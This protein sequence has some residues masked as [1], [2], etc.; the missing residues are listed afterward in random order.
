MLVVV[1]KPSS[2]VYSNL[3]GWRKVVL[4]LCPLIWFDQSGRDNYHS[5]SIIIVLWV[6]QFWKYHPYE[7]I[8]CS[9]IPVF[10]GLFNVPW[11]VLYRIVLLTEVDDHHIKVG[12]FIYSIQA[13]W[14]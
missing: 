8:R 2:F 13:N 1:Q 9:P 5:L 14:F 6:S 4:F 10:I 3:I 11:A 7:S 12:K